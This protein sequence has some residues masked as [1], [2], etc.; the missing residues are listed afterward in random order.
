MIV[1]SLTVI[2]IIGVVMVVDCEVYNL[3]ETLSTPSACDTITTSLVLPR[4]GNCTTED[5]KLDFLYEIIESV[6]NHY[7]PELTLH[8][9]G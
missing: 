4:Y 6:L 7:K 8:I 2:I 5:S 3:S 9:S 1:L